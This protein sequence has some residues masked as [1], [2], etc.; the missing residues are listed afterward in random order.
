VQICPQTIHPV[1]ISYISPKH[2]SNFLQ[3]WNFSNYTKEYNSPSSS[4]SWTNAMITLIDCRDFRQKYCAY[5]QKASVWASMY[6]PRW[7]QIAIAPTE[8][9]S[10]LNSHPAWEV[11]LVFAN[12]PFS[13]RLYQVNRCNLNIMKRFIEINQSQTIDTISF[14][15]KRNLRE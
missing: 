2:P 7:L 1:N 3:V 12:L 9:T 8:T 5:L 15:S 10:F 14:R 11:L 13:H 4:S 6:Q